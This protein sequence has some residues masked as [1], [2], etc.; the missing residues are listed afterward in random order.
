M[1]ARNRQ[2]IWWLIAALVWMVFIYYKSSQTYAEQDLRPM[3]AVWMPLSMLEQWLP[4]VEFMYDGGLVTWKEPYD[5][6]EFFIRKSVHVTEFAILAFLVIRVLLA[7][8]W[9]RWWAI[10][11]GA[12][13]SIGYAASDRPHPTAALLPNDRISIS[14][15]S[16]TLIIAEPGMWL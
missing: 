16:G 11:A 9:E 2:Y 7:L 12:V 10:V 3:L 6:I 1:T 4:H 14:C 8:R 15:L 13:I 5:F